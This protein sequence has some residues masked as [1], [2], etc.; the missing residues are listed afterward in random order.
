MSELYRALITVA[1]DAV[2]AIGEDHAILLC[3]PAAERMFG[4]PV[5]SLIGQTLTVRR[6]GFAGARGRAGAE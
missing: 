5:V 1:P 3:N 6:P 4:Y 2:V